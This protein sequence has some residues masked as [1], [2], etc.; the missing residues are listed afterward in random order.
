MKLA[1]KRKYKKDQNI[2][3]V[4]KNNQNNIRCKKPKLK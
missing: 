1:E 2:S 3:F 4:S